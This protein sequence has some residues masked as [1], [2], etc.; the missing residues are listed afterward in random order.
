MTKAA[1][2]HRMRRLVCVV[3]GSGE[4]AALPNL[5]TRIAQALDAHDWYV[6]SEPVRQS[7]SALVDERQPS[8]KRL[9]RSESLMNAVEL[10]FRRPADAVL[11]MCDAD[12]DCAAVWGPQAAAMI[13]QRGPGDAVMVVREYEAWLL[14]AHLD[15]GKLGKRAVD[16]I[17]NA[18][19]E[20]EKLV[21]GYKPTVHQLTLTR[22]IEIERLRE[23]SPSFA[24]LVRTLARLFGV[25][26]QEAGAPTEVA[27]TNEQT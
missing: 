26:P 22:K 2:G 17:R 19:G 20:L 9:P 24:K 21:P 12:D 27:P 14:A 7:R 5:C 13:R 8:P 23:L 10:A 15:S 16:S 6:D 1:G 3:E 4:V 18:K 25:A 11:V